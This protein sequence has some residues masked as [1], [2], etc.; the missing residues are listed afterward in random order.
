MKRLVCISAI[1]A[2]NCR[3][4]GIVFTIVRQLGKTMLIEVTL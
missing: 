2:E 4:A 3:R 1:L